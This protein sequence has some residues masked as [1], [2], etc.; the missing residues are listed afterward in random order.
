MIASRLLR[1]TLIALLLA[2]GLLPVLF[3]VLAWRPAAQEAAP[4]SCTGKTPLLQPG[5][6]LKVMTWNVQY[7]A[8]KRHVF[9]YDLPGGD[10][11]D[12]RPDSEDL[13]RTLDEVVRVVRE[14]Q[15]DI[16]LL[17]ELHDG[18]KASDYQDQL[19]LLQARLQGIYPCSAQ[20]FYWKSA[21][22]PHP[23]IM[24]SVGM[25]L[26]TL[27]RY[28]IERAERLQ[29]PEMP[30]DVVSRLF[31]LK[32]AVLV[33]YLPLREGGQLAAINTHLDAFAQG[34]DTMRKQVTM[35]TDL[36]DRLQAKRVPWVLGGDFNLLPPGQYAQLPT[37]QRGWYA[38]EGELRSLAERYPMVP[39][40]HQA[41]GPQ[42]ADWY[43]HY[44][45]D[46]SVKGPDRTL[47]YLFHSPQLTRLDAKVRQHDTLPIS[48]H[49]PLLARLLL[50]LD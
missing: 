49:L 47:D 31:N 40:L 12:S 3:Y 23:K 46:P 29:L 2:C 11:P 39:D 50:P 32:R 27:S 30:A 7:L 13:A 4:V 34:D 17:Q 1:R 35:T 22:V 38:P 28:R 5:Q 41:S 42:R 45:N 36:L 43:T 37:D 25:K 6:A 33:S 24:G 26:G 9:W 21:F 10:G 18:A 20:A 44:P 8:G 14:E 15:P 48:D 16:L 19:A